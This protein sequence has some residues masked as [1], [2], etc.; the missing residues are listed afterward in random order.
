MPAAANDPDLR[1]LIAEIAEITGET[2]AALLRR[3]LREQLVRLR[4]ARTVAEELSEI[5]LRN[6]GLGAIADRQPDSIPCYRD[7]GAGN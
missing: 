4:G 3:V 1:R 5:A 6:V 2:P 7:P